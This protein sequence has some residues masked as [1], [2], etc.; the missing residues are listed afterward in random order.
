MSALFDLLKRD[1]FLMAYAQTGDAGYLK[2]AEEIPPMGFNDPAHL[3]AAPK[4][5]PPLEFDEW[6][7]VLMRDCIGG[8]LTKPVQALLQCFTTMKAGDYLYEELKAL[9][10][11]VKEEFNDL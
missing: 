4:E 10:E 11:A 7:D 6:D 8:R 9:R 3:P 1:T 2:K 5:P